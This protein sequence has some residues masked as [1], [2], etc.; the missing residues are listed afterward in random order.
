MIEDPVSKIAIDT[1]PLPQRSLDSRV[2]HVSVPAKVAFDLGGMQEATAIVLDRLGCA[3]C[4]SGWD[5]R[6]SME[7]R[8]LFDEQ[9]QLRRPA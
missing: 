7:D 1:V 6:F 8:F 4:H 2:V 9:L 3:Q 5:I